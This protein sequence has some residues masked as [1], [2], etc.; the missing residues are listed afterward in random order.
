MQ[1]IAILDPFRDQQSAAIGT[2]DQ[3]HKKGADSR[4]SSSVKRH[5]SIQQAR[6]TPAKT[7]NFNS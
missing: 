5:S 6:A 2:T 1:A 7:D 3:T 4:K